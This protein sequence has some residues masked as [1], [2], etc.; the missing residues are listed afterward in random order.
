MT[1]PKSIFITGAG[2][3]IGRATAV[4]FAGRGWRVGLADIDLPR[5]AETKNILPAGSS[6]IHRLDVRDRPAWTAALDTFTKA[7][8]G[9][10]DV[11]FNNAGIG[12]GGPLAEADFDAIDRTVAINLIGVL[13]GARI[14]FAYLARGNGCL[15]NTAS[16]S[17]IYG[18]SGLA[19]YSATKCAICGL[20]EALDGEW[21]KS[22]VRVRDIVPG[23]V[24][25]PLL[26]GPAGRRD[27]K[28]IRETVLASGLEITPV[29]AVAE[30]AWRA[31]HGNKLHTYVGKTAVQ[32]ALAA[33]FTPWLLR[34]RMRKGL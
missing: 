29:E 16:A 32:A 15:L 28:T 20:T 12:T 18:T 14:G 27:D 3:G 7:G 4:L 34:R 17:G 21:A 25:T 6:E 5:L 26:C 2:S 33:R 13:N 9:A 1:K 31:V 11:L 24:E 19:T 30:A 23:F 10:L 8:G 22:N